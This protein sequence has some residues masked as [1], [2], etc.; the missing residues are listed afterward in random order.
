MPSAWL[1]THPTSMAPRDA[2]LYVPPS[3]TPSQP[4]P[5]LV[6]LH[7]AGG[8]GKNTLATFGELSVFDNERCLLLVPESRSS[9]TWDV[10]RCALV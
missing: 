4:S 5:L 7:G 9:R 3:Y 8:H 1:L 6:M 2:Y 10:I